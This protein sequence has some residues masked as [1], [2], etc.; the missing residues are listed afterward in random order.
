MG[1]SNITYLI[2]YFLFIS[3]F[4]TGAIFFGQPFF[5]VLTVILICLP[6]L[7]IGCTVFFA[8]LQQFTVTP[9]AASVAPGNPLLLEIDVNNRTFFPFLNF[10]A[11]I[12]CNSLFYETGHKDTICFCASP[13]SNNI[14]I[15]TLEARHL[16]M[17]RISVDNLRITDPLHLYTYKI[18][19]EFSL[20]IPIVPEIENKEYP[21]FLSTFPNTD[22]DDISG[23]SGIP[24]QDIRDIRP[25]RNGDLLKNVHWKVTAKK[26][27]LYIKELMETAGRIL[28]VVPDLYDKELDNTL[29]TFYSY[30]NFLVKQKECVFVLTNLSS[31][32]SP[33]LYAIQNPDDAMNVLLKIYYAAPTSLKNKT[34]N[35]ALQVLSDGSRIIYVSGNSISI[36]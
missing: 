25:F 17:L 26:D 6:I 32:E 35:Q 1:Q 15:I 30:I 16:G 14:H 24:S 27:E 19:K 10:E 22:D 7:S 5:V 23:Y 36:E 12:I 9:K 33:D 3:V 2:S 18:K 29:K 28:I 4:L 21:L 31:G 34:K 13:F 11:D 20:D 8:P